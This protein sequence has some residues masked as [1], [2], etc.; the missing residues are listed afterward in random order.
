MISPPDRP[1]AEFS[2]QLLW[3][4]ACVSSPFRASFAS[5]TIYASTVVY[6]YM[7]GYWKRLQKSYY[8]HVYSTFLLGLL[9]LL[10]PFA[11]FL[12]SFFPRPV[13]YLLLW[14]D[15]GCQHQLSEYD[16]QSLNFSSLPLPTPA[17]N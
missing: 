5:Q 13:H 12:L 15:A 17:Y 14:P 9:Q 8:S 6:I 11:L 10:G 1:L 7:P 16:L 2:M 4:R 3:S